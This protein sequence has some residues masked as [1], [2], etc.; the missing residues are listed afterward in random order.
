MSRLIRVPTLAIGIAGIAAVAIVVLLF[1]DN[2]TVLDAADCRPVTVV[3]E[4]SGTPL[5]GIED[6]AVDADAGVAY[7]SAQ[8]RWALET[9]VD[10][11]AARLP[12]GGIYRLSVARLEAGDDVVRVT[13]LA[14]RFAAASDFHP[15]GI[16]LLGQG[17]DT[18]LLATINRR[19]RPE[20]AGGTTDWVR[21]TAVEIFAL[22]PDGLR[23]HAR[24]VDPTLCRPNDVA[25]VDR[26][27]ILV[28][29][30]HAACDPPGSWIET[31]L[32]GDGTIV[33]ADLA[34]D[35]SLAEAAVVA[36]GIPF[37]NGIAIRRPDGPVLVAATRASAVF[38]FNLGD[39]ADGNAVPALRHTALQ[40]GPDN[41]T[42]AEVG[43]VLAAVHP[44]LIRLG[45]YRGQWFDRDTAPSRV[46][47]IC[48]D[49]RPNDRVL[50]DPHGDLFSA[51]TVAARLGDH[52]LIGS[53]ADPGLMV[54]HRRAGHLCPAQ[55]P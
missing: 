12:Q 55:E 25:W 49:G 28:T 33:R 26:T 11:G 22:A 23:H 27:K 32:G 17:S 52:I 7:L 43:P 21:E 3:D 40:G 15:H 2:D 37:A 35:L 20:P 39:L 4:A 29:N 1:P 10:A 47:A 54:C 30:D 18:P 36:D 34:A 53:V 8:D 46:V 19:Y 48:G 50:D 13:N 41:L 31:L 16:G 9:A 5:V 51:A 44:S 6:I 14:A 24:L 42:A 38:T 45:L